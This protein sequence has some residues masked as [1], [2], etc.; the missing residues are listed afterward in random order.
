MRNLPA[1]RLLILKWSPCQGRRGRLYVGGSD[2]EA[3]EHRQIPAARQRVP[4]PPMA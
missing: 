2:E 4:R 1:P 3:Y